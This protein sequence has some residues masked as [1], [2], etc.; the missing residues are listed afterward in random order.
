[1][2]PPILTA[3]LFWNTFPEM[4]PLVDPLKIPPPKSARFVSNKHCLTIATTPCIHQQ[5][6]VQY[7][8]RMPALT[9]GICLIQSYYC[10]CVCLP[11]KWDPS[12]KTNFRWRANMLE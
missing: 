9:Y 11:L 3:L 7:P 8:S 4:S 5:Q 6:L 1:M 2:A 10:A 12:D